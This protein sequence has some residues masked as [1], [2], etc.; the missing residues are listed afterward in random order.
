MHLWP[1]YQKGA[2][3]HFLNSPENWKVHSTHPSP[4]FYGVDTMSSEG[5]AAFFKWYE[6]V[7]NEPFNFRAEIE[8]YCRQ[9]VYILRKAC[10][11]FRS[12][13]LETTRGET[14]PGIDPFTYVTIASLCMS[15]YRHLFYEE[16]WV[17][18]LAEEKELAE[19]EHRAPVWIPAKLRAG[20]HMFI[21]Q[22]VVW[23][24]APDID[25][26]Q[27]LHTRNLSVPL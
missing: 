5:R 24:P 1:N 6:T 4:D 8:K 22:D 14:T 12:L 10:E 18:V 17:V 13:F 21:E 23:T 26:L 16:D 15:V 20:G 25:Q 3:P 27:T 19:L 2:F 11:K 9:D 7:K